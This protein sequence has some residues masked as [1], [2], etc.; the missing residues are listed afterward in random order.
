MKMLLA[1]I[2]FTTLALMLDSQPKDMETLA[3]FNE[4]GLFAVTFWLLAFR[5]PLQRFYQ[6]RLRHAS[7]F[8]I[9]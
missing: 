1:A 5:H 2:L 4:L 9:A 6:Q 8:N 7:L 3:E